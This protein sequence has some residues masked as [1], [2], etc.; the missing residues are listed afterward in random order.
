MTTEPPYADP[1]V[2]WC[3]REGPVRVPSMPMEMLKADE[4]FITHQMS[5]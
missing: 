3:G 1:L 5:K 4:R 2:R